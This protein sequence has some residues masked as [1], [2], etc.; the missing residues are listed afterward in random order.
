MMG[1]FDTTNPRDAELGPMREACHFCE[2]YVAQDETCQCD[3]EDIEEYAEPNYRYID[4]VAPATVA[5]LVVSG[6][7]VFGL[8][9]YSVLG[10]L[11]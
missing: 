8:L 7:V 6:M 1:T 10:W 4:T 11:Q 2:E 3:W 9:A 5:I